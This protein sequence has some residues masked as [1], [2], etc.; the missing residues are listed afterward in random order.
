M[1]LKETLKNDMSK[2]ACAICGKWLHD[3]FCFP[4]DYP[5]EWRWC[6]TCAALGNI[7]IYCGMSYTKNI[8]RDQSKF[9]GRCEKVNKM[10]TIGV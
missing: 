10:I 1:T 3:P 2:Y 4:N 5:V 6:C 8:F 7:I 9:L